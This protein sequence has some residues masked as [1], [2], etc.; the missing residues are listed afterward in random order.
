LKAVVPGGLRL[1]LPLLA[2]AGL[3]GCNA[4]VAQNPATPMRPVNAVYEV[5]E[6]RMM[7]QGY[8]VVAYFTQGQALRGAAGRRA[9]HE[10][11]AY[12]FAS[13]ANRAAFV[14]DP[15]RYQPAYHG[16]DATRMVYAIP[17]DGD[18]RSWRVLDGRLFIFADEA[19]KAA[20]ELNPAANIALADKYWAAEVAG[21]TTLWQRSLRS[22]DRVPHYKSRD[23]L[24]REV[25]AATAG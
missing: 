12:H 15:A 22:I 14:Q 8:D 1:A 4:L 2:V 17:E 3:G 16:F 20:F 11:V 21:S 18:P 6:P 25:A 10:G 5:D 13:D 19:S 9:E 24:A 23:E 7:L